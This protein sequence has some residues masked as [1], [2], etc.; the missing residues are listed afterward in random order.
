L[1]ESQKSKYFIDGFFIKN[2]DIW[3]VGVD[4]NDLYEEQKAFIIYLMGTLPAIEDWKR[5]VQYETEL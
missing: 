1:Q 3:P 4:K 2:F 5:Q